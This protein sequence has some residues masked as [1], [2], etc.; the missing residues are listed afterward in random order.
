MT[1]FRYIPD[2]H[3]NGEELEGV[4]DQ[5]GGEVDTGPSPA[6]SLSPDARVRFWDSDSRH[7]LQAPRG[8][9]LELLDGEV[10]QADNCMIISRNIQIHMIDLDACILL[11]LW[12]LCG[13]NMAYWCL[14]I[15]HNGEV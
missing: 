9:L 6:L 7:G 10:L 3:L 12:F 2:I 15:N 13:T 4:P 1:S 5:E 11:H 14:M 8:L